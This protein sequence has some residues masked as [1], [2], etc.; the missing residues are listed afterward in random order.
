MQNLNSAF[1]VRHIDDFS[2]LDQSMFENKFAFGPEKNSIRFYVA[3]IRCGK[4]IRKLENLST[5]VPGLKRLRVD[6]GKNLAE[7]QIDR[8]QQKFSTIAEIIS[9]LGFTPTAVSGKQE[10][11]DFQRNEDQDELIRLAVAGFCAANIMVYSFSNYVGVQGVLQTIF[12]WLSFILYL[13]VVTYVA[14]PFYVSGWSSL[15]QRQLSIDLPMAIASALGFIFSTVQL[16]RGKQDFYFDSLSGFLFLILVSRWAQKRLQRKFLRSEFLVDS[17]NLSRVRRGQVDN[18]TW[19][20][21]ES[22]QLGD[23]FLVQNKETL[24]FGA[25]L[26]SHSAHFG[27]AWLT[28]EIAP[29]VFYRGS[30]VPAGARLI[31]DRA[32]LQVVKLHI[33]TTFGKILAEVQNFS[34]SKNKIISLADKWAQW[35]L[36][37]VFLVAGI[38]L[39]TFWSISPEQAIQRTLA[40]IILA[41]PCAM[42]FGT[43]LA[44]SSALR[45]AQRKGL[46]VRNANVFEKAQSIKT[47]FFDKTGTVTDADLS[48]MQNPSTIP[49]NLKNIILSLENESLHPIAFAFRKSFENSGDLPLVK[50]WL[51]TAGQGVS[52]FIDGIFYELRSSGLPESEMSCVLF[53]NHQPYLKFTFAAHVKPYCLGVLNNLRAKGYR[54][55]LISGDKK[56]VVEALAK[57]LNFAQTDTYFEVDP[58][59]KSLIVSREPNAMMIGDGANDSLAMMRAQV[60]IAV[61]GG[62]DAALKSSDVYL[63]ETSLKGVEDF[64]SLSHE[65][66]SLIRQN[67]V[68]SVVYNSMA[69][70]LALM[71]FVNPFVAAVLM[72]ISSGFILLSTWIRSRR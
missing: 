11:I 46:I 2:Y 15:Q 3:G 27:M 72:P 56:D 1:K 18:W 42:A 7:I 65:S 52:G 32:E 24:A 28:G 17:L 26:L 45:K 22:I 35:L 69:G 33:E 58:C 23:K 53:K 41:C 47:I 29:K 9:S 48:L 12:T 8:S 60:S 66:I 16:L 62:M 25:E 39:V 44:L 70:T 31:S 71:G 57:K 10:E 6:F 38:F 68:I 40:L 64:L 21:M 67:L 37:T 14:W 4:C 63:T 20:P 43:P 34:L 13:P 36:L 49:K 50:M 19:V 5:T 61:A 51:E 54:V 59:E 55:A 30:V